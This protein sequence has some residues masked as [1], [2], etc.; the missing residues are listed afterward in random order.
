MKNL[1]RILNAVNSRINDCYEYQWDC[2]GPNALA[3]DSFVNLESLARSN[4]VS[5]IF[6]SH[7]EVVYTVEVL[8]VKADAAYRWVNPDY[9]TSFANEAIDR[10]V[11][12]D[13]AYD[14][15]EFVDFEDFTD[16][17]EKA[18]LLYNELTTPYHPFINDTAVNKFVETCVSKHALYLVSMALENKNTTLNS[19]LKSWL[20]DEN[21]FKSNEDDVTENHYFHGVYVKD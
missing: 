21:N 1:N 4:V 6:D 15:V 16:I 3:I 8:N 14:D 7:T 17:V 5:I 19:L 18:F 13:L 2:F 11:D 20:S 10:K 12:C 9:I